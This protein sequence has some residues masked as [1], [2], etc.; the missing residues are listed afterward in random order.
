MGVAKL[1]TVTFVKDEDDVFVF[2]RLHRLFISTRRNGGIEL[3]YRRYGQFDIRIFKLA[4][5]SFC[6]IRPIDRAIREVIKFFGRLIIQIG[7][8]HTEN[9]LVYIGQVHNH[10]RGFETG[11]CLARSSCMPDIAI[12]VRIFDLIDDLLNG[13]IL[14]G[15]QHH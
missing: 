12:P 15:P 1:A 14:I 8:V 4:D 11:Q 5:Q 3:L 6:I 13:V 7:A 9:H 2:H 10:L